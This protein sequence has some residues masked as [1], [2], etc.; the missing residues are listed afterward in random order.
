MG[1]E[2][3]KFSF[4][5]AP[6]GLRG[7]PPPADLKLAALPSRS[8]LQLLY[9]QLEYSQGMAEKN[10]LIP[11]TLPRFITTDEGEKEVIFQLISCLLLKRFP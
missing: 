10:L 7:C 9:L 1:L 6:L 8:F 2:T 3:R 11:V 4:L 5:E